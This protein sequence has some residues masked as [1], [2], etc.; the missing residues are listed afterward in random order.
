M[1]AGL[2]M[3]TKIVVIGAGFG[4]LGMG[5]ALK[6]AGEKDFLILEKRSTV[7]GVWR[8]ST[9]PG[10]TCDVP[11]H[12]YSFSFAPYKSRQKHVPPQ[13]QILIYL[14]EV[15]ADE[16]LL[17]HLH[18][19]TKVA[20]ARF[21]E[22]K[23]DWE[24][25]T[26]TND[27][28]YAEV[29]IFAVGQLHRPNFPN[30]PGLDDFHGPDLH[31]AKW[32][33]SVDF[34]GKHISI[35]GTGSGAGQMMPF[36]ASVASKVTVYQRSPHWVLPKLSSDFGCV[37]RALLRIPGA[38]RA[39]R[40]TLHYA[41][42]VLLSPIPR[43]NLWRCVVETYARE[44]LRTEIADK[45]IRKKLSPKYPL[46]TKRILFDSGFYTALTHS[47]VQLVTEPIRSASEEGLETDE[48]IRPTDVII[49]A[50]GFRTSEFLV[51]MKV[52]GRNG[53]LLNEDWQS[54]AEAFMGLAIH[55]YPNLFL[56]A[57]PNSFNPAGSNPEMK[58]VQIS[59][60]VRCLH[61]KKICDAPAIEVSLKA[62]GEYQ[63]WLEEKMNKTIW[64]DSVDSWYK[65]ESE[66]ITN[67]WP[68]SLRVFERLLRR[69][70]SHSFDRFEP[71]GQYLQV[72]AKYDI[73]MALSK[74]GLIDSM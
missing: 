62:T 7:G 18:L 44:Y 31:P 55:G 30:L 10:C 53:R 41:A 52:Q 64:Q 1:Q 29:V 70:P 72:N 66:K 23:S 50:T 6:R 24:V 69:E 5:S 46:G 36:L 22:D 45:N 56:I 28:I 15:A 13:Q 37:G 17:S 35:I 3:R 65:H 40:K 49:C 11:S 54:G 59:Y 67:P 33:R 68:D 39:Y 26:A 42:D 4:G 34:C 57:G 21:R 20:Q 8:D 74:Q 51:P 9:Y 38:H 61:W 63:K 71:H 14:E 2:P 25:I 47:N 73:E 43:L 19:D 60:I 32:D 58:E 48:G 12:L 16:G 27:L